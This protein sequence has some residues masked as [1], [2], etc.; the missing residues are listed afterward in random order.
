MKT[1]RVRRDIALRVGWFGRNIQLMRTVCA[2]LFA[3]VAVAQTTPG[4]DVASVK[5]SAGYIMD[6]LVYPGGRLHITCQTVNLMLRQAYGL[7]HYQISGGPTW[8]STDYFD[9]EAKADGDPTREQMM[10]MLQTLLADRFQLKARRETKEENVYA[11]VVAKGG[12]KLKPP[13]GDRGYVR[14]W[15]YDPPTEPGV[16]YALRG[17]KAALAMIARSIG[18]RMGRPVVAGV[19]NFPHLVP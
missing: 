11:L 7:E 3:T 12:H 5:P 14:L 8:L 4:F 2:T 15:R 10:V 9:I 1:A 6:F 18:Q 16:H 13:T 19:P 17:K